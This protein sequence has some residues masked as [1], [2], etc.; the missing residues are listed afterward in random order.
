M[1]ARADSTICPV[2]ARTIGSDGTAFA[3]AHRSRPLTAELVSG[4]ALVLT[5][6]KAERSVIAR[7]DP[8]AR[9]RTFTL[10]EA[11]ALAAVQGDAPL[12]RAERSP[13][14]MFAATLNARRG[15]GTAMVRSEP[16]GFRRWFPAREASDPLDVVDGHNLGTRR[17]E[18]TMSEV[19]TSV[20]RI[21]EGL[22]TISV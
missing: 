15:L 2:V 4:A 11:A 10:R 1:T 12:D 3:N 22:R 9:S 19:S 13:L 20:E 16:T 6:S 8:S 18:A 14:E 17:H 5:A 21:A 7:L